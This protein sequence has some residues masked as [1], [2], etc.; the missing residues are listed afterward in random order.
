MKSYLTENNI[1][2]FRNFI[3]LKQFNKFK[4]IRNLKYLKDNVCFNNFK[5]TSIT[6]VNKMTSLKGIKRNE[7]I[8]DFRYIQKFGFENYQTSWT[9]TIHYDC[10]FYGCTVL[11][12]TLSMI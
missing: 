10:N 6:F 2:G 3:L 11:L 12:H 1:K 8:N 9:F 7:G 5:R 4:N